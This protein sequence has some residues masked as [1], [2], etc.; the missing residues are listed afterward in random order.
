MNNSK[1]IKFHKYIILLYLS[2]YYSSWS[3]SWTSCKSGCKWS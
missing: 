1:L 3:C 2:V